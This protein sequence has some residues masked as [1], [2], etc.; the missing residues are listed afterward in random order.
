[1]RL[2]PRQK[3]FKG[4]TERA[5]RRR[6]LFWV[7]WKPSRGSEQ[8][9][10]RPALIIHADAGNRSTRYPNT[11]IVAVSTT[12]AAV[13]THV[14]VRPSSENGLPRVSSVRCEEIQTISKARLDEYIGRLS[15][16][17]MTLVNRA[18]QRVQGLS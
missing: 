13:P 1:M 8:A 9:G 4:M 17:E 14:E 6:D 10:R 16:Q 5:I 15:N 2:R 7:D 3:W 18:L 11:I 12:P